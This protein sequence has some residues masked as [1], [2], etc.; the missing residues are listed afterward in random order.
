MAWRSPPVFRN[1]GCSPCGTPLRAAPAIRNKAAPQP[2]LPLRPA[3]RDRA[4]CSQCLRGR[5]RHSGEE[6]GRSRGRASCE[7]GPILPASGRYMSCSSVGSLSTFKPIGR[8]RILRKDLRS[9]RSTRGF[10]PKA[11]AL[12]KLSDISELGP[13]L[14]NA[15]RVPAM[16]AELE[17][18]L[19]SCPDAKQAA[20]DGKDALCPKCRWTPERQT[21]REN[22]AQLA[23]L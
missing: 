13:P 1:P 3:S 2:R 7:G 10:A 5:L 21:P 20:V 9:T 15:S 18:E 4:V 19:W 8:P 22:L 6:N 11:R 16:V 14:A 17:R 23:G 12:G